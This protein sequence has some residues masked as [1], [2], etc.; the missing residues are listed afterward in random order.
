VHPCGGMNIFKSM[1]IHYRKLKKED[2]AIYRKVRLECLYEFPDNF[3]STYAEECQLKELKFE[4]ILAGVRSDSFMMGAFD[5]Q[6]LI[7]LCGF[8]REERMKTKHRGEIVQMYVN[9]QYANKN[10]GSSLLKT[11]IENAFQNPEIEQISLS[12]VRQNEKA[13]KVYEHLGFSEYGRIANYFKSATR[14]WD[15]RFMILYRPGFKP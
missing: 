1:N 8:K 15:Q 13:N 12:V 6:Q 7:G 14:Y 9:K 10:I 3:G 5:D 2:V 11:T 4:T